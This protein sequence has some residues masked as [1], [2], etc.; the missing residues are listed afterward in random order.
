[1]KAILTKKGAV[2]LGH[3]ELEEKEVE[4]ECDWWSGLVREV[5]TDGIKLT[6]ALSFRKGEAK[7]L[8]EVR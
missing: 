2:R 1:M 7:I 3:P 4:C 5:T 8:R 6:G